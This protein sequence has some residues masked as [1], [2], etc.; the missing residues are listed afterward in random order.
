MKGESLESLKGQKMNFLP[1]ETAA[2]RANEMKKKGANQK[3]KGWIK[4]AK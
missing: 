1:Y 3:K 4:V 2:T